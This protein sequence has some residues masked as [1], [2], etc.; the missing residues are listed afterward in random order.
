MSRG[1][2]TCVGSLPDVTRNAIPDMNGFAS[3]QFAAPHAGSAY[4][5]FVDLT[6]ANPSSSLLPCDDKMYG[7]AAPSTGMSDKIVSKPLDP[8]NVP[9][10]LP[11][12]VALPS[13]EVGVD[14]SEAM[15]TRRVQDYNDPHSNKYV[16]E[17]QCNSR[18]VV[19][20]PYGTVGN[21]TRDIPNAMENYTNTL[22]ATEGFAKKDVMK[23]SKHSS[24]R[25]GAMFLNVPTIG[26][27][28]GS[29]HDSTRL[30]VRKAQREVPY[31]AVSRGAAMVRRG[32]DEAVNEA[33][34]R[35]HGAMSARSAAEFVPQVHTGNFMSQREKMGTNVPM[36]SRS[37][38]F[39]ATPPSVY[40]QKRE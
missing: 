33:V 40:M 21:V 9:E 28:E 27:D 32:T 37:D 4:K 22:P 15:N 16:S 34:G 31:T 20:D 18:V 39:D 2:A 14:Y 3:L 11:P 35:R 12:I 7:S 6:H 13:Y 38:W 10:K 8:Y 29:G 17:L 23:V 36:A 26:L 1:Q 25:K 24:G 5:S 30:A 19:R